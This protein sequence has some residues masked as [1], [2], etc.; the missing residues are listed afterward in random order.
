MLLS[1]MG[2]EVIRIDRVAAVRSGAVDEPPIDFVKLRGRRSV[3]VD[4]KQPDGVPRSCFRLVER[5]DALIEGFRPGVVDRIGIGAEVCL[6][7]NPRPVYAHMTGWGQ[8][9]SVP[10]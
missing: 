2:A 8:H 5:A 6:E 7:R 9:G 10:G 3:A 4:L 1:D